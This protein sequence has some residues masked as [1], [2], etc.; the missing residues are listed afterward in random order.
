MKLMK[1]MKHPLATAVALA[2]GAG[3]SAAANAEWVNAPAGVQVSQSNFFFDRAKGVFYTQVALINQTG[4]ALS[5]PLRLVVEDSSLS[6]VGADGQTD[7]SEPYLD[8]QV[9][10]PGL[11][12]TARTAV[13]RVELRRA[14]RTRP[15]L[16]L[17]AEID[18][19]PFALQLLHVADIDSTSATLALENVKHFSALLNHFRA[20]YPDQSLAL[21]S[22]DNWIPGPRYSAAADDRL[23]PMLGLPG[24]GRG[25]VG[26][27]NAMGF[28]ASTLGNHE[29]DQSPSGFVAVIS[30]ETV[31][32]ANWPGADF[33]Y[34]SVNLD[35]STEPATAPL[36]VSDGLPATS[37]PNRL[38]GWTT[39]EVAGQ[40]IGVVGATTPS[41]GNITSE[42]GIGVA[43]ADAADLDALAAEI[44]PAV[45]ALTA[46]G[47]NKIILLAHMQQIAIEQAL[48]ERLSDVDIIVAGGSNTRLFDAD[49]VIRPGDTKQGPYP[50]QLVSPQ[51]EPVLVVN[52]DGDYKYLGR[53]VSVFDPQGLL[54]LASLDEAVNGAYAATEDRLGDLGLSVAADADADVIDIADTLL[55]VID[56]LNGNL[57]GLTEVYL[58]GNRG[59]V[60]TEEANLGNLTADANLWTARQADPRVLVSIKNGGGIRAAIGQV[61]YPPGSTNPEDLEYLPPD[62][63]LVTQLDA[64]SALAFNNGL[65][66]L[67]VTAEE[68]RAIIE[69]GVAASSLD[70]ANTQGRFPQ[71]AGIRFSWDPALPANARV[72]SLAV[73]DDSGALID[74]LVKEGAVVGD[75]DRG[76]RIVTLGFLADGGDGYPFPQT[77]RLDIAAADDA[78]R[79]GAFDFA[80]DGSEQDALAE[81]LGTFFSEVGYE[82]AEMPA[83]DDRRNQNLG[84]T[85]KS[86]SV[87]GIPPGAVTLTKIGGLELGGAEI[88]TWDAADQRLFVTGGSITLVDLADPTAPALIAT[89]HPQTD[90]AGEVDGFSPGSVTSVSYK[91]GL[92]AAA[93]PADPPTDQGRVAFYDAD[94]VFL[95]SL[96]AGALPDMVTWDRAGARALVANEGE[97]AARGSVTVIDVPETGTAADRIAGAEVTQLDFTQLDGQEDDLRLDG[98]RIFPGQSA[99]MDLEPEY[100]ALAADDGTA[101]VSLQENNALAVIDLTGPYSVQHLIALG[102]KDHG[103]LENALDPS[104]HDG[105]IHIAAWPVKGLFMPD[106]IA[107]YD[108][109]LGRS[110]VLTANE[111]D[112]RNEDVRIGSVT[113]DETVFPDAATLRLNENL[114]RLNISSIDGNTDGDAAF[115]ALYSYGAR[116]FSI[117]DLTNSVY[118]DS[119]DDIARVTA[120]QKPTYFN[121]NDGDPAEFDNRSDDKGAEPEAVIVGQLNGRYYAFVGLERAG[122]GVMVFDVTNPALPRFQSYTPGAP[123]GD[124]ALEGMVLIPAAESPSGDPLL[125]TANEV[126]GTLAI[127]SLAIND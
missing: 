51:G 22:G 48:A 123:D 46:R 62:G 102:S 15:A 115:E 116:S 82:L 127:Y 56:E 42:G 28:Q 10:E 105:G 4:N 7:G 49:D 47:V 13:V 20:Q 23:A 87:A 108:P 77:D 37:I 2:L 8:I 63:G 75:P 3:L 109:G 67:T 85:G 27:L 117:W 61:L 70:P 122:G 16:T 53:L 80:A 59:T 26:L 52:T 40:T 6:V 92:L 124:I 76:L 88:L 50:I 65:T 94:G 112:A 19:E 58:D 69:H 107:A 121:A 21:S 101:F 68:L 12:P 81:Y 44:Q 98:V 32:G 17:R 1:L 93:L 126:S 43:P 14:G 78:P 119:N 24:N 83:L 114:G 34:V 89:L 99:S 90:V 91:H 9:A 31:A 57:L 41:L 110:F 29:L 84:L 30:P 60:R 36:V 5:G 97:G 11:A 118:S 125:A 38:S 39:I 45:D 66:L 71:V 55:T 113:L 100:I 35:F 18:D 79:T 86:D 104:N 64:Q 120:Q 106:G 111:G 95:G 25:D 72:R 96:P 103:L 54:D 74:S 73:V 33:P